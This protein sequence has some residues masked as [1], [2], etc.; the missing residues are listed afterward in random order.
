MIAED[1]MPWRHVVRARTTSVP[2]L[3]SV[4]WHANMPGIMQ[5]LIQDSYSML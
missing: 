4:M 1:L 5:T 2:E 3:L